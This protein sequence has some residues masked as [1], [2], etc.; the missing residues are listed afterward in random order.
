MKICRNRS[1][2][3]LVKE[4]AFEVRLLVVGAFFQ[5]LNEYR[6]SITCINGTQLCADTDLSTLT[7]SP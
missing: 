5:H 2:R 4:I 3:L 1:R 7:I 6:N